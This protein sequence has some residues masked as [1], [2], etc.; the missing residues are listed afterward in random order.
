MQLWH[1]YLGSGEMTDALHRLLCLHL[2][3]KPD[4]RIQNNHDGYNGGIRKS[5][6]RFGNRREMKYS[7][8]FPI[9]YLLV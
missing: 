5:L 6:E 4:P 3:N 8:F 7:Y 1:F 9:G 2:L